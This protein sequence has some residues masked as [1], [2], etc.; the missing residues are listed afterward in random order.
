MY[1]YLFIYVCVCVCEYMIYQVNPSR[2]V[3]Q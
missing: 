1:I 3:V 2:W